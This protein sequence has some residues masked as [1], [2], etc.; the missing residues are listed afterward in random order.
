MTD[1]PGMFAPGSAVTTPEGDG[2]V[3]S[4]ERV[5]GRDEILVFTN[6][7]EKKFWAEHLSMRGRISLEYAIQFSK[8][9]A[10]TEFAA[11]LVEEQLLNPLSDVLYAFR[12]SRTDLLP[13]QFK[14]VLKFLDSP[15]GRLMI[16]DEVG[17][18]KTIEAALIMNELRAR[19]DIRRLLVVVS[20][21]LLLRKWQM[22]MRSRFF[23][24]LQEMTRETLDKFFDE[25]Q[26]GHDPPL[27][28]IATLSRMRLPNNRRRLTELEPVFDLVIVDEAHRL[29]NT[30]TSSHALGETLNECAENLLFLTATPL[31]LGLDDFYNLLELIAPQD[32]P[33]RA[34][35]RQLMQ[36]T[37]C[38]NRAMKHLS[39]IPADRGRA[40]RELAQYEIHTAAA[41][42]AATERIRKLTQ[43]LSSDIEPDAD[44]LAR[45]CRTLASLSP[46]DHVFTRTRKRDVR[47]LAKRTAENWNVTLSKVEYEVIEEAVRLHRLIYTAKHDGDFGW[48]LCVTMLERQAASCLVAL[49]PSLKGLLLDQGLSET[50]DGMDLEDDQFDDVFDQEPRLDAENIAALKSLL[51]TVQQL[52]GR[53][54]SKYDVLLSQLKKIWDKHPRRKILLFSFFRGT[55]RYLQ[56]RLTRDGVASVQMDGMT[57]VEQ[58]ERLIEQWAGTAADS[59]VVMLSSEI[60]SEGLDMQFC[61]VVVNYDMPWNP[62]VVEQRIGRIDRINQE[63]T[64]VLVFNLDV[65]DTI[66]SRI[67]LRLYQRLDIFQNAIGPLEAILQEGIAALNRDIVRGEKID[68][69]QRRADELARVAANYRLSEEDLES[70]KDILVGHTEFFEHEVNR[71]VEDGR[72]LAGQALQSYITHVL[73]RLGS[74][75][76]IRRKVVSEPCYELELGLPTIERFRELMRRAGSGEAGLEPLSRSEHIRNYFA[77]LQ[78][79]QATGRSERIT[80]DPD[81]AGRHPTVHFIGHQHPLVY[82]CRFANQ[83][84]GAY[85]SPLFTHIELSARRAKEE[86]NLE[87]GSYLVLLSSVRLTASST[88]SIPNWASRMVSDRRRIISVATRIDDAGSVKDVRRVSPRLLAAIAE[89]HPAEEAGGLSPDQ[90]MTLLARLRET[91]AR[92][93][94]RWTAETEDSI[95]L[96][97]EKRLANEMGLLGRRAARLERQLSQSNTKASV[98]KGWETQL[99]NIR[100]RMRDLPR[101]LSGCRTLRPGTEDLAALRVDVLAK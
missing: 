82:L 39:R 48:G 18:G 94:D 20:S 99:D 55:L 66:D 25:V 2:V 46:I 95:G 92:E 6:G 69:V 33:N 79:A 32:F 98:R 64:E 45:I 53:T 87:R 3:M 77:R 36:P 28:G 15:S 9:I 37:E 41:P 10:P 60:G 56:E 68:E 27:Y 80:F 72:F 74:K 62:M 70:N 5:G 35:F 50:F 44:G 7:R 14:P 59:P 67:F 90:S 24:E 38:I 43:R 1:V 100:R 34:V 86:G 97:F 40:A 89:A 29:R 52:R 88:G 78:Q 31:N 54:D 81:Y 85:Q 26:K 96:L 19:R 76:P 42:D 13:Y 17:L 47:V 91:R 51:R 58:R 101:N 75:R 71:L 22:E 73:E 61:D 57:P 16:A 8:T 4:I 11:R 93:V 63:S 21:Q 83:R 12:S 23:L 65:K 30:A 49:E 84:F